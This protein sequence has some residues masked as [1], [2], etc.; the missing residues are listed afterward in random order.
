MKWINLEQFTIIVNIY[1]RGRNLLIMRSS[2]SF[3]NLRFISL[4]KTYGISIFSF[5]E[6]RVNIMLGRVKWNEKK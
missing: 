4:S 5:K 1:V 3:L 6:K 2:N